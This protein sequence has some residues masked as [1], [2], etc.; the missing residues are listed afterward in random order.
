[1]ARKTAAVKATERRLFGIT[2]LKAADH[3]VRRLKQEHEPTIHGNKVWNSS[4]VVMDYLQYQGLPMGTRVMEIGCGWGLVGIYCARRYGARVVG[5]DADAAV[6]PYLQLHAK[7]NGVEV[8]T[9]CRRFEDLGPDDFADLDILIGTDICFWDEMTDPVHRIVTEAVRAGVQQVIIADPGRPP[10]TRMS[11][12][13]VAEL[14]AEVKDWDVDDPVRA[15][16]YIMIVGSLPQTQ[17]GT[18]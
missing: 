10:F 3:R 5:V 2:V 12:R 13:C 18:P 8:E 7:V 11:D 15:R 9:R 17:Q 16:A 14:N 4:W 6:F 1:M